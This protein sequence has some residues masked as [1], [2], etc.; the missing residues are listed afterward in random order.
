M[1]MRLPVL[2]IAASTAFAACE[3]NLHTEGVSARE[4]KTFAVKGLPNVVLDTFDGAIEIHSWEKPEVEVEIEKRAME[5]ALIDEIKVQADQQGD[6]VTIKVTGPRRTEF[7][8]V[9]IG[10][11]ISPTAR[12]RVVVPRSSNIQATSGDGSIRAEAVEGKILLTTQDGS[13]TAARIGGDIQIRSGDGS[14]RLDNVTGKLDLET[15]DGSIGLEAQPSVLKARTGDGSIRAM[16]APDST[17]TDN[18]DLATSDGSVML[19]LPGLFNAEIDAETSDGTVRS[20][21]PLLADG[22][23]VEG[24]RGE[25]GDERRERRRILRAKMGDGG[26]ILKVRTG[27]GTIRIER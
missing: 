23:R 5:Q 16:I 26:K 4:T 17:M 22:D 27:D 13:V 24:R 6:V 12:L 11:H 15:E 19:Q 21:H 10:M 1:T 9:T 7:R 25:D 14:I 20:E 3:V 8:G 18:W 2:V